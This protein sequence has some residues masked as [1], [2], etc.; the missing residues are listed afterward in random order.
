MKNLVIY[1]AGGFGRETALLLHQINRQSARYNVIGFCD[2]GKSKGEI[3]DQLPVLGGM[4]YLRESQEDLSVVIAIAAPDVREKI[5]NQLINSRL[6]F[7]SL[8]HPSV[9]V[10]ES[11]SV[12]N[13]SIICSDVVMTV[14]VSLGVFSIV[15]LKCTLGHDCVLKDFSSLMPAVNISGNVT[16]GK[17]VYIGVGAILLQGISIGD[18]SVVGAG[19]VVNKSFENG[20]RIMGVPARAI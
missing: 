12:G 9:A 3:V 13:G 15:N 20:K 8:V 14:N 6:E 2:D 11:C 4:N 5:K 1:G 17:A 18:Y 10:S 19:A 16:V 7:P